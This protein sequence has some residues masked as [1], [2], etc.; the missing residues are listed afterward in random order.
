MTPSTKYGK[1]RQSRK[2]GIKILVEKNSVILNLPTEDDKEG[3]VPFGS[4]VFICAM[5]LRGW[6]QHRA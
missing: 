2:A 4:N 6:R 1:I 3:K 5:H